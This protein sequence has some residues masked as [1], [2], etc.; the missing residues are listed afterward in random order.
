MAPQ[1][2]YVELRTHQITLTNQENPESF[3]ENM[4][5]GNLEILELQHFEHVREGGAQEIL[6]DRIANSLNSLNMG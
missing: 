2:N 6:K 4:I 3:L 1:S 5:S